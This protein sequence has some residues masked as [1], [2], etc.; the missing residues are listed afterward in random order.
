[1]KLR[2]L[3]LSAFLTFNAVAQNK[4]SKSKQVSDATFV[5]KITDKEAVFLLKDKKVNE[6][7]YHTLTSSDYYKEYLKKNLPFGNYLL[8]NASGG[9]LNTVFKAENNVSL[10]FINNQKDFQFYIV[11]VKGNLIA[12]ALVEI[13]GKKR[14][15]YDR[16][17]KLYRSTYSKENGKPKEDGLIKVVHEGVSNFFEYDLDDNNRY[18]DREEREDWSF[19]KKVAYAFPVKYFWRPFKKIHNKRK[20]TKPLYAGYMVFSKPI[21][22]P[23]DTVKFKAYLINYKGGEIKNKPADVVLKVGGNK[24]LATIN[25]YK[26]GGYEYSFVL[27]D[28]LNLKLDRNYS[29]SL[30]EKARNKKKAFHIANNFRYEDYELKALDFSLRTDKDVQTKDSLI[31]VYFKATDENELAVPDG[32]VELVLTTNHVSYYTDYKV[33]LPDT[34]W[35]KNITLEPVGETKLVLPADIFPR[36][37][38][39]FDLEAKFLNSNNEARTASK[40]LTYNDSNWA[41]KTNKAIEIKS[42]F[43]KDSLVLSYFENG[44]SQS[45]SS[46]L[47]SYTANDMVINSQQITLPFKVKTDYRAEYYEV[48]TP[49]D[50]TTI[51][52]NSLKPELQINAVQNKDSLR[53]VVINEHK[54]PFWYTIFSDNKVFLRG[55]THQLDTLIKNNSKKASHIRINYI[56]DE[57]EMTNEVS[58]FYN[59]NQLNLKLVAPEMVYPGQK[60][61][62][63]VQVTDINHKPVAETDVTAQAFTAKF[64]DAPSVRLPY[65]GRKYLIRKQ[66]NIKVEADEAYGS[67]SKN[68]DKLAWIK[69]SKSLGLDSIEY[70]KFTHP[71]PTYNVIEATNDST[72]QV[73]PF[74]MLDGQILPANIVYIDNVPVFFSQAQQLQRYSF[75]VTPGLHD[76]K[77]RTADKLVTVKN[78]HI[79]AG[80]K[81]IFSVLA[82]TTNKFFAVNKPTTLT[83]EESQELDNYMIRIANNF[84]LN[85]TT[86]AAQ[87]TDTRLLINP[88]NRNDRELVVG[89]IRENHLTFDNE[90]WHQNFMKEAGYTYT[91][92]P[93][94]IKQKSNK[95]KYA[96]DTKLYNGSSNGNTNIANEYALKKKEI[97]KIWTDFLDLRSRTT[98]LFSIDYTN[99]KTFGKLTY[100]IDTAFTNHIP[101]IKNVIAFKPNQANYLRIYKGDVN[102]DNY[103]SGKYKLLFL[104]KDNSYFITDSISVKANGANYYKWNSFK[105]IQADTFSKKLDSTIKATPSLGR[106]LVLER[107]R[108]FFNNYLFDKSELKKTVRGR[109]LSTETKKVLKGVVVTLVDLD[110]STTSNAKGW[111][112]LKTPEL[113]ALKISAWGYYDKIVELGNATIGDLFL[114]TIGNEIKGVEVVGYPSMKK[115]MLAGSIAV[116]KSEELVGAL[117]GRAAGVQLE[118]AVISVRGSN[119]INANQKPLVILDGVPYD[120]D[121]STL[122]KEIVK[123]ITI[124]KDASATAI[125]GSRAANGVIIIKSKKGNLASNATGELVAQQQTLRTNFNDEGFWQP[126]LITDENGIAKFT[127]K[128]PDDITKWTTRVMAMNGNKQTGYTEGSIKSFKSL[129][130]NFVSPLFAVTGDSINVIGKLMNYTPLEETGIRKFSYNGH[131]LRN[132][133]VKF[134]NSLIDTLG[135][136]VKSKDSLNFEYTLA[137]ENGY[138]DGERRKIPVFEAGVK[139]TKG[140]F[141]ALLRDT[142]INY[143]FDKNLGKITLRAEASV[144][145]TLLDEMTKL[146]NYEYLCNEQLASKLKAL[147]LEKRV[148]KYLDQKFTHEK[149]ITFILKKLQQNK[150]PQGTWG[151]W[152]NSEEQMWISLHVVEALLQAQKDGYAVDLNK[153]L[154]QRYLIGK[155]TEMPSYNDIQVIRLLH[156]LDGKNYI[157]DWVLAYEQRELEKQKQRDANLPAELLALKQRETKTSVYSILEMIELKQLAGLKIDLTAMLKLKKQTMFGSIYWG[158]ENIRF[159]DNSIQN[160]LLAYRILKNAG[161]YENELD[162]IALYFLEQRKDGQWRN[163]YEASLILE[164][165]LPAFMATNA[166]AEPASIKVNDQELTQ[167]PFDTTIENATDLRVQK[168]GKTA[169]YFTAYQQFQNPKPNKVDKDFKVASTLMQNG[170]A[171]SKL[172]AGTTA[173]LKVD[174]EVRADADYVMIEIPIPAGCSYENKMQNFWGVET[175]RE[176]FKNKTSIFCTKMKQGKYT[177][178][179]DLMPRYTGSYVLNPAKAELMYFPV[180]Y[181]REGMKKVEIK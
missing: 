165:I 69:W 19:F 83:P 22:K 113:G 106:Q 141:S 140:Y 20:T 82:D 154:L 133:T 103:E 50:T 173:T 48:E 42:E 38:F 101:Y 139:E 135:I 148:R 66:S 14:A 1:M 74:V 138:F 107:H 158:E 177:F 87:L 130:A 157:K 132:S 86:V 8:V 108:R 110:V 166:K 61:N 2:L 24:T 30:E 40:S 34:L 13:N 151:W 146:R 137:Q 167:F 35:K 80:K 117:A 46:K 57:D 85:K 9:S 111:F 73:A 136:V 70:F 62:M 155:L 17:A 115:Q 59:L 53:V 93:G 175:H 164:T 162:K 119:S 131:E 114:D 5:Y 123:D 39:S 91:F 63:L 12:N 178:E 124:L 149:D 15:Q 79:T 90:K 49:K 95:T 29:I 84:N 105:I 122:D 36:A 143:S 142:I 89:P 65:L 112:E 78:Y 88:N 98:E 45:Q 44:K 109:I 23:L 96:F 172:K 126:K 56:W 174:V 32:R 31:T 168:T 11:D 180:F 77:I 3:I 163:T 6:S 125:Y 150:K 128:F 104:L 18:Y 81:T 76:F 33:F 147:L 100:H 75:L 43:K 26:N 47:I 176:Y 68:L 16:K 129:S 27:A 99:L 120:G 7:F 58:A 55:Y 159:W 127:V 170:A 144:F 64:K 145:P 4:L 72:T 92:E 21:Y 118:E 152:Q 153:P 97:D 71:N 171:S 102:T 28:S 67:V 179:I 52:I 54:I 156:L 160:T 181:G 161:G 169:V 37:N 60:V 10:Q 134:K 51:Y 116:L 121:I 94:L 41:K 25:P